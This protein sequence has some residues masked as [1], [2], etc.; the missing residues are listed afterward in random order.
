MGDVSI[1]GP[2]KLAPRMKGWI[3][4]TGQIFSGPWQLE[5]SSIANSI[6]EEYGDDPGVGWIRWLTGYH[7][8]LCFD[9]AST[10]PHGSSEK[11]QEGVCRAIARKLSHQFAKIWVDMPG[12][13][14][15]EGSLDAFIRYGTAARKQLSF[16]SKKRRRGMGKSSAQRR[17]S[18]SR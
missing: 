1:I 9:W 5:H 8:D 7:N 18:G 15:W 17:K 4:P 13:R 6:I 2:E 10:T 16:E 3:S 14:H 12:F 11:V